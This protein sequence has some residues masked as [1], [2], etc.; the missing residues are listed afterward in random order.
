MWGEAGI[1]VGEL[2]ARLD[3]NGSTLS[4]YLSNLMKVDLVVQVREGD[5]MFLQLQDV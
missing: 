4:N 2:R 5:P 1:T 3:I